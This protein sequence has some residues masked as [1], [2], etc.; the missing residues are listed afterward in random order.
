MPRKRERTTTKASW[1][2]ET[3]EN[4]VKKLRRGGTS[5][6]KVSKETGISY[7]T[8]KKRFRLAKS[9]DTSYK[10]APKLGRPPVFT[11][12]QEA[13]LADHLHKM[14]NK[15]Y[16]LTRAQFCKICYAMAEKFDVADRFNETKRSAGRDFLTGFFQRHPNLS[17]RKPEAT[18]INRILGFNKAEV[19]RF[20]ENLENVMIKCHFSSSHIYN[21]DETG[22]TTVQETE[23]IIG[24][25]GTKTCRN[26]HIMGKREKRHGYLC[27]ECF[28][29]L[30]STSFYFPSTASLTA[31]RKRWSTRSCLHMFT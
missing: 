6:Y 13:I 21:M 15:F 14:S 30:H 11:K 2:V 28:R 10:C 19:D 29:V 17:I 8:L 25:W 16:G 31:A 9:N 24:A 3:L 20:F 27:Y 5:V 26:S 4:A 7:S 23:K 18:S 1:T 12:E 22:V